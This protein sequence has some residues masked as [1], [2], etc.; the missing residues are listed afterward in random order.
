MISS[1]GVQ[2]HRKEYSIYLIT[3]YLTGE[4]MPNPVYQSYTAKPRYIDLSI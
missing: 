3:H 4:L 2:Q 1:I